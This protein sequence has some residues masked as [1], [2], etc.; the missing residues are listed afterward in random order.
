MSLLE[1]TVTEQ[2]VQSAF[3]RSVER[4]STELNREAHIA[5]LKRGLTEPLHSSFIALE[6]SRPWIIYWILHGLDLLGDDLSEFTYSVPS[7]LARCQDKIAGG[8]GG[9][10]GQLS[11]LATTYASVSAL[12]CIGTDKAL[13]VIDRMKMK[14]FLH[15]MKDSVTGGFRMHENGE[16]DIRGTYCAISVASILGLLDK[17]LTDGVEEYIGRC[18]TYEGGIAGEP[19]M[20]AHGGYGYCG[21]A[22][23]VILN[24][25]G[26]PPSHVDI[27]KY[28][29]WL[30][31]RQMSVEGG[32]QGRTNKLVDSCYT[33]WQGASFSLLKQL[34][35]EIEFM[36]GGLVAMYVLLAC[37]ADNGGLRD[38]PG[39]S[40]DFYHSCYALS[41]L[42]A[43]NND[44]NNSVVYNNRVE[45]IDLAKEFFS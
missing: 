32:F 21:L 15:Q 43:V 4:G 42:A 1:Q 45:K 30:S 38:K 27:P 31:R 20:E 39:K 23:L 25:H 14:Q 24:G 41:G 11:H 33:F 12:V 19:G 37:Q 16:I 13:A 26:I 18:Q 44:Y 7:F 3:A 22:V 5:F 6:A 35:G 10:P 8:F 34:G 2:L 36:S 29:T 9:G 17:E 40:P 28:T